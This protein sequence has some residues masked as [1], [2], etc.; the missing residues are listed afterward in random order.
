MNKLDKV[1]NVI[2]TLSAQTELA[3]AVV[4]SF[5]DVICGIQRHVILVTKNMVRN[6]IKSVCR[7]SENHFKEDQQ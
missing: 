7:N 2:D 3:S 6:A 4:R 1:S 5:V